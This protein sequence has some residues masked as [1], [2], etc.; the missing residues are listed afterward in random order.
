MKSLDEIIET[1]C[2]SYCRFPQGTQEECE[3]HCDSCILTELVNMP[4]AYPDTVYHQIAGT[5]DQLAKLIQDV[6][7]LDECYCNGDCD[8]DDCLHE[9][10]CILRWLLSKAEPGISGREVAT[11]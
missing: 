8:S 7:N 5:P 1:I 9:F 11:A 6:S 10:D 4:T 3:K 2:D